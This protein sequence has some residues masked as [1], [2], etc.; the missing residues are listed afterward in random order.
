L[1]QEILPTSAVLLVVGDESLVRRSLKE[2]LTAEG[3]QVVEAA[4]G[5]GA[6]GY[7][8]QDGE[9]V[10][11]VLLDLKLPDTDG[12]ALLK[13]IKS[14]NPQCRAIV[15][16]AYGTPEQSQEALAYG[17]YCI[18]KPFNLGDIVALVDKVLTSRPCDRSSIRFSRSAVPTRPRRR[19]GRSFRLRVKLPPS[20]K[21]RR[22]AVASA[23]AGRRTAGAL[24][25]AVRTGRKTVSYPASDIS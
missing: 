12:I 14:V 8:H 5:A 3:Y 17:A 10:D 25:E 22:T 4:S 23:E 6:L 9:S 1:L 21:L 13:E 16:A 11:L 15:M 7:L 19:R 24:A 20:L 2:R 18:G